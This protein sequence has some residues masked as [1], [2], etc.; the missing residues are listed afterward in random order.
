MGG[1]AE[2]GVPEDKGSSAAS[3]AAGGKGRG[4]RRRHPVAAC[5][6]CRQQ[7]KSSERAPNRHSLS[8]HPP[9]LNTP[10]LPLALLSYHNDDEAHRHTR[11][12]R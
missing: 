12:R 7:Y 3:A 2:G 8:S 11:G 6:R 1:L 9:T 4:R 5:C 10:L